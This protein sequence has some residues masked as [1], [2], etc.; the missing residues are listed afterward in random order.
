[1]STI[2]FI[3]RIVSPLFFES[4]TQERQAELMEMF[5]QE[6]QLDFPLT[7]GTTITRHALAAPKQTCA[8]EGLE[9]TNI[10]SL[11][12]ITPASAPASSGC[13]IDPTAMDVV[14]VHEEDGAKDIFEG[15]LHVADSRHIGG[16]PEGQASGDLSRTNEILVGHDHHCHPLRLSTSMP[17]GL[18]Q[19]V[20]AG[21][22][23]AEVAEVDEGST[24]P[25]LPARE[26]VEVVEG[27]SE[28]HKS[29]AAVKELVEGG[30]SSHQT[31]GEVAEVV[32]GVAATH[33]APSCL[34]ADII[35][36]F[37]AEVG[38]VRAEMDKLLAACANAN[39][40]AEYA[41]VKADK[42]T[43]SSRR[44]E[45]VANTASRKASNSDITSKKALEKAIIADT[46][47]VK[48][49]KVGTQALKAG[50]NALDATKC[51]LSRLKDSENMIKEAEAEKKADAK[52]LALSIKRK[53]TAARQK[54][55]KKVKFG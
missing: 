10:I 40:T 52:K 55:G 7:T 8:D 49:L 21:Q 54:E 28:L 19:A 18:L 47:A 22:T 17:Q 51:L 4:Q 39:V 16:L 26:M 30:K 35:L 38:I 37:R 15:V 13:E 53:E 33:Q 36:G 23:A 48:A 24:A 34:V 45:Q 2:H 6:F 29:A 43:L 31:E 41:N 20:N 44:A 1:M 50:N 46:T 25:Y 12:G 9:A 3:F 27:F 42:A 5:K 14:E 11:G 32:D